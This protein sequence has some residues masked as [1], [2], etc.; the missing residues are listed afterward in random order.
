MDLPCGPGDPTPTRRG[1]VSS[2]GGVGLPDI[3]TPGLKVV[4]VGY[5]PSLPAARIGHYYAGKQNHFYVL[6]HRHGLTPVLLTPWDD[7][8]LLTYGIGVT[9]MCPIPTAQAGMLPAGALRAGREALREKLERFGPLVVCFNGLGVYRAYFN[10]PPAS[11]GMQPDFVG[12][13]CV[14]VVPST[15]PANNGLMAQRE[16]AFGELARL[17]LDLRQNAQAAQKAED[18]LRSQA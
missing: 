9:D 11:V 2:P 15:S 10:G 3:L 13:S 5:N 12:K 18:A 8:S 7:H 14:V 4:F 1:E 17:V 16:A 6:L